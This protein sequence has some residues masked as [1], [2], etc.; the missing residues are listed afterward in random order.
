MFTYTTDS[1]CLC[2]SITC[3]YNIYIDLCP[4]QLPLLQGCF[5]HLSLLKFSLM[6]I[7]FLWPFLTIHAIIPAQFISSMILVAENKRYL[8]YIPCL[9]E[10]CDFL[11]R[12]H[13]LIS[14]ICFHE[15]LENEIKGERNKFKITG[16]TNRDIISPAWWFMGK[17]CFHYF[18]NDLLSLP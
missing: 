5:L 10:T 2:I 11:F 1:L 14:N 16:D 17:F 6:H 15:T 4:H 13:C 18:E 8:K 12:R 7:F 3:M 9:Q